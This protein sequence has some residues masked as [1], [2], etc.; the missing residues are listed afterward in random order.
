MKELSSAH[1]K[2]SGC[3]KERSHGVI[4]VKILKMTIKGRLLNKTSFNKFAIVT[5]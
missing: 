1:V 4:P 3:P 2:V 5:V